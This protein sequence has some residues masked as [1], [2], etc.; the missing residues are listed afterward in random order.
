VDRNCW[1][2]L[3]QARTIKQSYLWDITLDVSQLDQ[4]RDH[5]YDDDDD[6]HDGP[7]GYEKQITD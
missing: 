6:H 4:Y 3:R 1:L 5:A 2:H 7:Y